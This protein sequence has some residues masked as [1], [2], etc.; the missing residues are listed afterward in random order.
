MAHI[1]EK[2]A[3]LFIRL[4]YMFLV[5]FIIY[6]M[7]TPFAVA[8]SENCSLFQLLRRKSQSTIWYLARCAFEFT[9]IFLFKFKV[10]PWSKACEIYVKWGNKVNF[11][12]FH[13]ERLKTKQQ[14]QIK[15]SRLTSG[16]MLPILLF[17][18]LACLH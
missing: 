10:V 8:W 2:S 7:P 17:L 16:E 6:F 14:N 9:R 3:M 13:S 5:L 11:L 12:C 15:F 18:I 1:S 4:A